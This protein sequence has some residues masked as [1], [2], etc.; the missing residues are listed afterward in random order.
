M[1]IEFGKVDVLVHVK[2]LVGRKYVFTSDGKVAL[3]KQWAH[4]LSHFP[5]QAVVED[6]TAHD[7]HHLQFKDVS[8]V[9]PEGSFCF[10]LTNPYYGS[11][12]TVIFYF[13]VFFVFNPSFQVLDSAE[14]LK[15]HLVKVSLSVDE[16]PDFASVYEMNEKTKRS[17]LKLSDSATQLSMSNYLFSRVTGS[18]F[19][20]RDEIEGFTSK[21]SINIGLDLK[22][23]KKNQETPGYTK[24][25][26]GVWYYTSKAVDL[27]RDYV[28]RFPQVFTF[29]SDSNN[30][31]NKTNDLD[32]TSIFGNEA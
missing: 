30:P 20:Q 15:N 8:D 1:G 27:V 13:L 23:N 25:I 2:Q 3:E 5:V 18:L 7:E 4:V 31:N 12:G 9:F 22:F 21:S 11:M 16:E 29:L 26:D 28:S 32:A 10:S 24:K 17:Y 19:I 6:L 14:S